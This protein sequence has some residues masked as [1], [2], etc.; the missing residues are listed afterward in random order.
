MSDIPKP[1]K[2]FKGRAERLFNDAKPERLP[3]NKQASGSP[4]ILMVMLDDVGFGTCSTFGGPIPT[5]GVDKIAAAGLRFNQFH[6]TALCSPTRAALLTGRNHHSVHMGG[7]TEIANSFPAYDSAIPPE[8]ASIAEIL[9]Q[10]GYSTGYFGKWHLTPSWE[11]S[12]AG[13]FDRWP[14]GMGFERFYGIIGAEASHWEPPVYDQTTPIEPHLEKKDYHLTEDLADKAIEWIARQ[15]VSAPDKPFFCYFAPAAVHAPHH[16]APEWSDK[17]KGQFDQGWDQL[18]RDIYE[19]QL[20]LGV[21]PPGTALTTRPEEVPAWEEYPDSYKPV[22]ARLMEVFAGFMAHTDAQVE[23]IIDNLTDTGIFDNTVVIYLTGDNGASAEGT[24][25]GAWSAPSFQ[26]GVHED[27]QWLLEHMEDFGTDRCENHYNVGWA[28]ALD[29]P[30]QWMKQ[31]ASHFGGTRNALAVSWPEGIKSRGELRQQFHHVIDLFPTILDITGISMPSRVNGIKQDDVHGQSMTYSFDEATA[32]R[33]NTTQ[34]FEI[35]GNRAIYQDGW[36]A[37]CFHGRLP[38]IRF[39]GYE[40]DGEQEVWELYNITQDFSQG[41]DLA[42]SHP[43][44]LAELR[45]LF[46][47]EAQKYGVYPLRDASAR[48]GGE[49]AVPHS[50]EGHSKMTYG[51]MHVRL[52]EHGVINLKNTSYEISA[53]IITGGASVGVIACQGGNMAGWSL[54][55]DEASRPAFVYNWFGHEFTTLQGEPLGDGDH[56]L[57]VRYAHDG[58]FAAGGDAKLLVNGVVVAASRIE[59]TVPVIFS[60]SGE[61]FDVGRDTGSPVGYYPHNF[62]FSGSILS[63]TLERLTEPDDDVKR[64]ERRGKF[65]AGLSSQ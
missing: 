36:M 9:K 60:M 15:K 16:V 13:P 10:N 49:Y 11:Q 6:T 40:F 61:T 37:S 14:T 46:E 44:K 41:H 21:I 7:I 58:G 29:S 28:W 33:K 45:A 17:F 3:L 39:A 34:Y 20:A 25:H 42:A 48:R 51:P 50:M 4:N 64:Q 2:P 19:R 38:W 62:P 5:P 26:N 18:R 30:F 24:V 1:T 35:L 59:R 27:P 32:A 57:T 54:Y 47:T 22:A 56:K 55:L 23:R 31:V 8:T 63:V 43:E 53:S 52:P 12:P 65:Q